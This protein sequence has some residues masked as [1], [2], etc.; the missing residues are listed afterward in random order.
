VHQSQKPEPLTDTRYQDIPRSRAQRAT[1]AK[2]EGP[3]PR[4]EDRGKGNSPG[5]SKLKTKLNAP[6]TLDVVRVA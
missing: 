2:T 5:E 6:S 1:K 3:R 4:K